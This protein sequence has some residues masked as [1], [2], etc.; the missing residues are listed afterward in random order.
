MKEG[1]WSQSIGLYFRT[2]IKICKIN[3]IWNTRTKI[4]FIL[5]FMKV[6]HTQK[7]EVRLVLK[8]RVQFEAKSKF[9]VT[10]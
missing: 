10:N 4:N 5:N 9:K 7:N 2:P 6:R 3:V 1:V 8:I